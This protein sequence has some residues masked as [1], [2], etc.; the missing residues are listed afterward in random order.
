M[1]NEPFFLFLNLMDAHQPYNTKYVKGLMKEAASHEKGL[2]DQLIE[3]VLPGGQPLDKNLHEAVTRQYDMG[4]ANADRAVGSVLERL[5]S[6]GLFEDT[7]VII[8][9]DH[10]EFLGEHDLV[11]H[12]KDVYEEGLHVP[13]AVKQPKQQEAHSVIEP[14]SITQIHPTVLAAAGVASDGPYR[15][16]STTGGSEVPIVAELYFTRSVDFSD[17]R[18]RHR[19]NR[20]RSVLY[21][22]PWKLIHASD[23]QH[24][25]YELENDPQ[26]ARNVF[27]AQSSRVATML[28]RDQRPRYRE[29]CNKPRGGFVGHHGGSSR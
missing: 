22:Y 17:V 21:D 29:F 10:G 19:F 8:T 27:A 26:E 1:I 4:I 23:G 5:K 20:I 13:L 24:E 7:L 3:D 14:V 6:L 9:S 11:Q 15:P 12:S 18:W 2:F 28:A 25:L 16:L